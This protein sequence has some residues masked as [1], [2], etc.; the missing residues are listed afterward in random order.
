MSESALDSLPA[1][2]A[3]SISKTLTELL[4]YAH[5]LTNLTLETDKNEN[6]YLE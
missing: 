4:Q 1:E 2:D 6:Q 3:Q 5:S